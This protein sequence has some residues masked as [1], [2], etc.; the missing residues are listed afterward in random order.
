M[1]R[2]E[3][4]KE[5]FNEYKHE[6]LSLNMQRGQPSNANFDIS[7]P[8]L[9]CVKDGDFITESGV[10]IRNYPGGVIG[11]K[12]ARELFSG[13]LG[14]DPD[15]MVVGNNASLKMLSN[16]LMW[17]LLRGLKNSKAPWSTTKNKIIVTVPGYDRHFR[18]LNDLGVEMISVDITSSGPDMDRVEELVAGDDRIKGLL[19]VPIYSNPTGDSVSDETVKRLACMKTAAEDFTIFA[20]N[21]YAVHHLY[22][23]TKKPPDL[24][25]ACKNAG[26][27][28]RVYIFGSTSKITFA[29][30]GIGFFGT[31]R[32][33]LEYITKLMG[34]EFIGPNKIEQYRHVKFISG[35][36]GG[37]TGLM[38][39][40]AE[41]LR[42]KF[43]AV[44]RILSRELG[45]S[46]LAEWTK[47]RGGYFISLNTKKPVARR[48]VE[49]A[50]EAGVSLTP[51]GATYP[52]GKDPCN[53]N[54]R[55]APT[56]PPLEDIEKAM[57]ILGICI[58]IAS[59][60]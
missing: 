60:E 49:L 58:K 53:S 5:K 18:L 41:I 13:I 2:L 37:I 17:G 23:D 3:E 15:E 24:L 35:F 19:F 48:V 42:P 40:H 56:R 55:I 9:T 26:N 39:T 1:D 54:I 29:G 30:A 21:A 12:E 51:A 52:F 25:E 32:E 11:L 6:K 43:Q 45:G 20:D 57:K 28:N 8:M 7:N 27:P 10:D 4:L 33:N 31:S 59:M 46:G 34:S 14:V 44:D 22:G 36:E 50:K 47:P 16:V 38:N